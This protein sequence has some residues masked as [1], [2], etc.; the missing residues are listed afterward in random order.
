LKPNGLASGSFSTAAL[1]LPM[2]IV[3]DDCEDMGGVFQEY[4]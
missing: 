3:L 4:L 2:V 1:A